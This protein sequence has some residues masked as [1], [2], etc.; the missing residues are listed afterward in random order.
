[1]LSG[2]SPTT[3]NGTR[4]HRPGPSTCKPFHYLQ[5]E[6]QDVSAVLKH[7]FSA[8]AVGPS[9]P[10]NA[11][12]RHDWNE[13]P[14][15]ASSVLVFVLH[16]SSDVHAASCAQH[17]ED[18]QS[19]QEVALHAASCPLQATGHRGSVALA[20]HGLHEPVLVQPYGSD[21]TPAHPVA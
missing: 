2:S 4:N 5:T 9:W 1:M 21:L 16:E 7:C 15:Q 11:T 19:R 17:A 12:L 18:S 20:S 13:P 10:S 8:V 3:R 6:A 14:P